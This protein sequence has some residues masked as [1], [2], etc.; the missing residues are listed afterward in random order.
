LFGSLGFNVCNTYHDFWC[1]TQYDTKF[2]APQAVL[3]FLAYL[4]ATCC[5]T[6]GDEYAVQMLQ[7]FILAIYMSPQGASASSMMTQTNAFLAMEEYGGV[8]LT[9]FLTKDESKG[10]LLYNLSVAYFALSGG[11]FL[12]LFWRIFELR[13]EIWHQRNTNM[14]L[15]RFQLLFHRNL[16]ESF[17]C[18]YT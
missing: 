10:V 11:L 3:G 9:P 4:Y 6:I 15:W 13:S 12:T 1:V 18:Y 2:L 17:K 16:L 8:K 14:F 5:V 7:L